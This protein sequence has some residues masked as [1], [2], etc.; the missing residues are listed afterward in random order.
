[1]HTSPFHLV[2]TTSDQDGAETSAP[3][4]VTFFVGDEA[5]SVNWPRAVIPVSRNQSAAQELFLSQWPKAL[6]LTGTNDA[7]GYRRITLSRNNETS[8]VL[9]SPNGAPLGNNEFWIGDSGAGGTRLRNRYSVSA[10]G[11]WA[12]DAFNF[13]VLRARSQTAN[14]NT[15]VAEITFYFKGRVVAV[16]FNAS[17]LGNDNSSS[18][19]SDGNSSTQWVGTIGTTLHLEFP[20]FVEVDAFSFTTA[21]NQDSLDPQD[22]VLT[23]RASRNSAWMLLVNETNFNAPTQRSAT[24]RRVP[25]I[26]SIPTPRLLSTPAATFSVEI[27]TSYQQN[28]QTSFSNILIEFSNGTL[29]ASDVF[30]R[31]TDAVARGQ[32]ISRAFEFSGSQQYTPY[33]FALRAAPTAGLR[34]F[35][36]N[37]WGY[38]KIVLIAGQ[39]TVVLLDSINGAPE[40]ENDFWIGISRFA[41]GAPRVR[42]QQT[43]V[44]ALTTTTTSTT[45]T[46]T[47]STSVTSTSSS[48]ITATMTS[49]SSTIVTYTTFTGSTTSTVTTIV[50]RP[51]GECADFNAWPSVAGT[52]C[53]SCTALVQPMPTRTTCNH[54]CLSFNHTCV[55]AAQSS[56][57]SCRKLATLTC[58]T[59]ITDAA[60]CTCEMQSGL[61]IPPP[62]CSGYTGWP[63][64]NEEVC[65]G[66]R[67]AVPF[68]IP[69]QPFGTTCSEYCQGFGH[70]CN[71]AAVKG[72]SPCSVQR[73]LMCDETVQG[74]DEALCSCKFYA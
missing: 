26:G 4:A 71:S 68:N 2:I 3:G 38:K 70:Q 24:T 55:A 13:T 23:G 44:F 50:S 37:N 20:F 57:T 35:S 32:C 47:S 48:S 1:M 12:F 42:R 21:L 9:D 33:L 30:I 10:K 49:T 31:E 18:L 27:V 8:I 58:S 14:L 11:L 51:T 25:F 6:E 56:G 74:I 61:T 7:W 19:V 53:G 54:F 52:V 39:E 59:A 22:F 29:T 15:Q 5:I 36:F 60:L 66:C 46:T 17:A 34:F 62:L 72:S 45:S 43:F 40:G 69:S 16:P 63:A 41:V 73:A 28:A 64:I 67:A 65:G